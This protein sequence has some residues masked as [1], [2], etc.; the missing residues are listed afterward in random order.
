MTSMLKL[1]PEHAS[2]EC[3]NYHSSDVSADS[4]SCSAETD[5]PSWMY[6]E[7]Y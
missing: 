2:L 5:E 4:R 3:S 1:E 7:L 6:G